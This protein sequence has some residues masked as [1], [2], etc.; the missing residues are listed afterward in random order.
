MINIV[1]FDY[2]LICCRSSVVLYNTLSLFFSRRLNS[3]MY[4][5]RR[6]RKYCIYTWVDVRHWCFYTY[7]IAVI[8]LYWFIHHI[9]VSKLRNV[10]IEREKRRQCLI[11]FSLSLLSCAPAVLLLLH[12]FTR[13]DKPHTKPTAGEHVHLLL[14]RGSI[15]PYTQLVYNLS[16]SLYYMLH[17]AANIFCVFIQK[18]D[19]PHIGNKEKSVYNVIHIYLI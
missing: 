3:F 10:C 12:G 13:S 15:V 17:D 1:S 9:D 2:Y 7:I 16:F 14:S 6:R 18:E 8:F 5:K 4:S 19:T 11:S